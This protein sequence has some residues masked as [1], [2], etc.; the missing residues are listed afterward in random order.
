MP[1]TPFV[2]DGTGR[3]RTIRWDRPA[4]SDPAEPLLQYEIRLYRCVFTCLI[5][6]S[7]KL[8]LN[9]ILT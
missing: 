6:F 9:S 4:A 5:Q 3:Q 7:K 8:M 1:P 2:I